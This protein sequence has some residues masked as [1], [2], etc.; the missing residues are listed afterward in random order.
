MSTISLKLNGRLKTA[1]VADHAVMADWL[2]DECGLTGCKVGCDQSVCGACTVLLDGVPV[3][4]CSTFMFV[5]AG[6]AVTT[7]EGLP[8]DQNLHRVQQ[9]FLD[10]GGFQCGFCTPG[11]ILSVVALLERIPAPDE[12]DIT[13][14]LGGNLCRC[15]GYRQILDAVRACL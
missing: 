4:A 10:C 12:D 1:E 7:I 8:N 14:W 15:T 6:R 9:A 13:A 5:A 3:A 11:M 2:R